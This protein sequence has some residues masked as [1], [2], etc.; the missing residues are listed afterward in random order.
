[1]VELKAPVEAFLFCSAAANY[2][3]RYNFIIFV[4]MLPYSYFLK[5]FLIFPVY[6]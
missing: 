3:I 2:R 1:M 6:D 5:N 4:K